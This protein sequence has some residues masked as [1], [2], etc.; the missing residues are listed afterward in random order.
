MIDCWNILKEE[1][2]HVHLPIQHTQSVVHT[3]F[4]VYTSCVNG[5][6]PEALLSQTFINTTWTWN[7]LQN[8]A[9]ESK[10]VQHKYV[11]HIR[12]L[13]FSSIYILK[14]KGTGEINLNTIF[15]LTDYLQNVISLYI[16]YIKYISRNIKNIESIEIT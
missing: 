14:L 9:T 13:K 12:N 11:S 1:S 5:E 3:D 4:S 2:T 10:D 8:G 16:L 15:Y 7:K 6:W